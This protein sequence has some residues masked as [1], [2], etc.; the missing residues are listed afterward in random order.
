MWISAYG[1]FWRD[2]NNSNLE[3]L[4]RGVGD[5]KK[6]YVLQRNNTSLL[7]ILEF[8]TSSRKPS[9]RQTQSQNSDLV[10]S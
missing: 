3:K 7:L 4:R 6:E 2:E 9:G 5:M 10:N 8:E 1:V